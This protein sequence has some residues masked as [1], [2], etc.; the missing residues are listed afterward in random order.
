MQIN[1]RGLDLIKYYEGLR[2][3]SYPDPGTGGAPYT[4]GYGSTGPDVVAGMV[5]DQFEAEAR[6]RRDLQRFERGVAAA[7]DVNLSDNQFSAL[8]CLAY[9]IGLGN[10]IHSTL[11]KELNDGDYSEAANQFLVWN[12]ANG[13]VMDGLSRRRAAER[14]LFLLAA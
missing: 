6:L 2:L 9:N 1:Q 12:R 8:V 3:T 11:L 13:Q 4:V 14:S 10:L 7:V 5:I